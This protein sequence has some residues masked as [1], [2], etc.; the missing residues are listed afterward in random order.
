MRLAGRVDDW[1]NPIAVK[2]LR[3]AVRG[4][5][6]TVALILSFLAQLVAVGAITAART[7]NRNHA[8]GN[9]SFLILFNVLFTACIFLI[10]M[11]SGVR[12][13]AERSD[14]DVDLL[15]ITTIR[16]WTIVWGKV[17]SVIGLVVLLFSASLPFLVF[18][19][20]LRGVDFVTIVIVLA[21]AMVMVVSQSILALF[22][23]CLPTSRP[24][25]IALAL[26]F[27]ISTIFT[28]PPLIALAEGLTRG[29][30]VGLVTRPDFWLSTGAMV[31]GVL[32]A[33]SV[34]LVLTTALITPPAANRA[35]GIRIV[36]AAT[37]LVWLI[38]AVASAVVLNRIE[39]LTMWAIGELGVI[40][41]VLLSA[42]SERESWGPRVART[43]PVNPLKR[44]LAFLFYSGGAGGTLW[45]LLLFGAT[46]AIYYAVGMAVLPLG[47]ASVTRFA[48][49]ML[50]AT[51][52]I[53]A[54]A[55]TAVLIRR[56]LLRRVPVNRTW[57]VVLA[58]FLLVAIVPSI[59]GFALDAETNEFPRFVEA[60]TVPNP[61]PMPDRSEVSADFRT[62]LLVGWALLTLLANAGWFTGQYRRFRR[63]QPPA[64]DVARP[65]DLSLQ[66]EL[67]TE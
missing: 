55:M 7:F 30:V 31:V 40:S 61:F 62:L 3:Q 60:V 50:D 29:G 27:F 41:L 67:T 43:I 64:S 57:A 49:I 46:I 42:T 18:S 34:L 37:W 54:Y 9:D 15:F 6:V 26:G 66:Q 10:P 19:Y 63:N 65:S 8:A 47:S 20:V 23:G 22:L 59:F 48:R 56:K 36:L 24:F 1:L 16:P 13:A 58:V 11:Y 44:A 33:N 28:Y 32:S 4:K 14:S 53:V 25:K 12:I 5:F 35:K 38:P 51:A 52:C 2:E 21:V 45:A 39:V 17:L